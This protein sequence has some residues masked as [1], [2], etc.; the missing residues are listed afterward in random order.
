ME[1]FA[2]TL[3]E[4][5]RGLGSGTGGIGLFVI[6]FFDSSLLSLP[7]I[8]DVLLVYFGT[9][10]PDL[11]Y[12]YALMTVAGSA[13]GGSLLY[14]LARLKGYALLKR[15]FAEGRIQKVFRAVERYGMLAIIVP[16]I[17]PPPFPFKIFVLSSGVLGLPYPRFLAAILIG[18]VIRYFGEAFLAVRYGEQALEYLR[19]HG[20]TVFALA[21]GLGIGAL[22][23]GLS[24]VRRRR[25]SQRDG[26]REGARFEA[27]W[28]GE[29]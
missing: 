4:L 15:K 16:A 11:A 27:R 26:E 1:G 10:F 12:Y 18:R 14:A 28:T 22:I 13:T 23:V 8:N 29:P 21:L 17:M 3:D 6:A 2:E 5:V 25:R 9:R 19:V 20:L 24:A 7:E